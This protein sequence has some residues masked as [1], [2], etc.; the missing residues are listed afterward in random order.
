MCLFYLFESI[1]RKFVRNCFACRAPGVV[2]GQNDFIIVAS[3]RAE[4]TGERI[5]HLGGCFYAIEIGEDLEGLH[6]FARLFQLHRVMVREGIVLC[7]IEFD[8]DG[9]IALFVGFTHHGFDVLRKDGS[10]VVFGITAVFAVGGQMR[11]VGGRMSDLPRRVDGGLVIEVHAVEAHIAVF[12]DLTDQTLRKFEFILHGGQRSHV[13]IAA[14]LDR[15][16]ADG[17]AADGRERRLHNASGI[18]EREVQM[19]AEGD[20]LIVFG[21]DVGQIARDPHILKR[22]ALLSAEGASVDGV[23]DHGVRQNDD[24][25]VRIFGRDLRE[26]FVEPILRCLRVGNLGVRHGE[27]CDD[28]IAVYH[29]MTV[30]L[31]CQ[32]IL[33][34]VLQEV[35]GAEHFVEYVGVDL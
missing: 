24:V 35:I 15:H 13:F 22:G 5:L 30:A 18:V 23:V 31:R 16:I 25:S 1:Y 3:K 4:L 14:V 34:N 28:V 33:I 9:A 2:C 26:R 19:S 6:G 12:V 21:E 11:A 17:A 27:K 8:G 32:N 20:D 7:R 10:G 29:A